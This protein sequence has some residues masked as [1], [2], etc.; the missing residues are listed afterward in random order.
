MSDALSVFWSIYAALFQ[1]LFEHLFIVEGVSIG[2]VFVTIF[3]FSILMKSLLSLP[4]SAPRY[5]RSNNK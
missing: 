5:R 1:T 4:R 3:I 2:W